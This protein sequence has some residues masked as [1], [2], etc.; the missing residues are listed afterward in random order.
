MLLSLMGI[1]LC[2]DKVDRNGETIT[3]VS[4]LVNT[5]KI[6]IIFFVC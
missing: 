4:L 1:L 6:K 2:G 5:K 3:A